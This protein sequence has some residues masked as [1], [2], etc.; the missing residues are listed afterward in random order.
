MSLPTAPRQGEKTSASRYQARHS[1]SDDRTQPLRRPIR[2]PLSL[3]A[4]RYRLCADVRKEGVTLPSVVSADTPPVVGRP[5]V[6]REVQIS[7]DAVVRACEIEPVLSGAHPVG[8]E[9]GEGTV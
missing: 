3:S 8:I 7:R 5:T 6:S 4:I 9:A 1:C 2:Y